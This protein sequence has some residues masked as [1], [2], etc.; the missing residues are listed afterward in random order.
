MSQTIFYIAWTARDIPTLRDRIANSGPL[1]HAIGGLMVAQSHRAFE[2]QRFGSVVWPERY[3]NQTGPFINV[4][5]VVRKA[6]EGR[7]PSDDDFRKRPALGGVG[8]DLSQSIAYGAIGDRVEVGSSRPWAGLFNYGGSGTIPITDTTRST[9]A[10]WLGIGGVRKSKRLVKA[11]RTSDSAVGVRIGAESYARKLAFVFDPDR[12][13][14][15]AKAAARPFVG[16]TQETFDEI[17]VAL[18][19]HIGG[20][21]S[22]VAA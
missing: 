16:F 10:K 11:G 21:A 5:P 4:A 14:F 8:S 19:D 13:S 22:Q 12:Q 18:A 20:T 15:T 1:M 6:G 17:V 2:E 3:P 7:K 9:L